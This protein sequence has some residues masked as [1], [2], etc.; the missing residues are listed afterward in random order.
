M[1]W[2]VFSLKPL[3]SI[4]RDRWQCFCRFAAALFPRSGT[5][6]TKCDWS[7]PRAETGLRKQTGFL[8]AP[9]HSGIASNISFFL[10]QA[11][12]TSPDDFPGITSCEAASLPPMFFGA[13]LP[14]GPIFRVKGR[15]S[16]QDLF[17]A[18]SR[19]PLQ[20]NRIIV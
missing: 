1:R 14:Y 16:N 7:L 9:Y 19:S 17:R 18:N 12:I 20:K 11:S 13:S 4:V 8:I 2:G 15:D 3:C 5:G 10:A 6:R